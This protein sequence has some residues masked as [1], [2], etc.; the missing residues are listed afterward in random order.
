MALMGQREKKAGPSGP[1]F[2]NSSV[3]L[4][5]LELVAN[6]EIKEVIHKRVVSLNVVIEAN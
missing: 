1:A 5:T 3:S 4:L 2:L 6:A